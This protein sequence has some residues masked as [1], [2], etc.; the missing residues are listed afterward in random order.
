MKLTTAF[1]KITKIKARTRIIQGAGGSSKTYSILQYLIIL[2]TKSKTPLTISIVS[3]SFPHLRR[4]AAKDLIDIL[5]AN[6][7]YD[8]KHHN[9]TNNSYKLNGCTIEWFGVEDGGKLRGAR[10]DVLF[11]NEANNINR[12]AFTQLSIRTKQFIFLDYN[13]SHLSWIREY[14][15]DDKSNFV[16]LTYKDNEYLSKNVIQE[17]KEAIKKAENGSSYWKNFVAVYVYGEEGQVD[18]TIYNYQLID[19]IPADCK[20]IGAGLDFGFND[21]NAL[22]KIYQRGINDLILDESLYKSGLLNNQIVNHIKSDSEL[23]QNIIVCDSARPEIIAELRNN[24][25]PAKAVKKGA[26]SIL[27]GISIVQEY[28]LFVTK[29]SENLI[30][31]LNNYTWEK[32]NNG[33]KLNTPIDKHNHLLDAVRYFAMDRLSTRNNNYN[34]LRWLS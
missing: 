11:V 32:D 26:G 13:P 23:T 7:L 33:E 18:G 3:E 16:K 24:S 17:Y 34:T 29:R 4:G 30:S 12:E 31:E 5:I 21:P 6:N 14:I 22:V 28:N 19:D 8:E 9:K 15:K 20:Y 25:I 1:K 27:D 10:R 2:C